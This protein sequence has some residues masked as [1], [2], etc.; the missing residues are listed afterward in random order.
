MFVLWAEPCNEE[1]LAD[2]ET[3]S[4]AYIFDI[5]KLGQVS[6]EFYPK[7][8][9]FRSLMTYGEND[10]TIEVTDGSSDHFAQQTIVVKDFDIFSS[11]SMGFS[12]DLQEKERFQ[13]W[14]NSFGQNQVSSG[15]TSLV[16]G[17]P[18]IVNRQ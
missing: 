1:V 11:S 7:N 6:I 4:K 3:L 17:L 14:L 9:D 5:N 13:G 16:T 15:G 8:L 12:G 2:I 10:L 18:N